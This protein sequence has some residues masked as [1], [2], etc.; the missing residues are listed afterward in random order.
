LAHRFERTALDEYRVVTP[1]ALVQHEKRTEQLCF[2]MLFGSD[3]LENAS[4]KKGD[5][6]TVQGSSAHTQ[7]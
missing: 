6:L 7:A 5:A 1:A 4:K 2:L 3:E